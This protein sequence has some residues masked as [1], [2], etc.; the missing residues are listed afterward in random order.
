MEDEDNIDDEDSEEEQ[1]MD[2]EQS[3]ETLLNKCQNDYL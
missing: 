3:F 1:T 2:E